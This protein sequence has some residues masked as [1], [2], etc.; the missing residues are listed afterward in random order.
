M[1]THTTVN[2]DDNNACTIDACDPI[3]G[4]SHTPVNA[5]D[6]LFCTVDACDP[7]T[8]IS[9]TPINVNDGNACTIDACDEANDMITHTPVIIDD[10]NAC[11]ID[12][13]DPI[14]GISH[15]PVNTDDGLFCTVDACDPITG[16]SHTPINVNDGNACTIDAC[17]EANDVITHT[18]VNVDDNNACTTDACDPITGITHTPVNADDGLFCTVDACDPITGISH[19]AINVNDGNACTIDACDEANDVITH[20]PVIIDDNNACTIDACDPITGI[21][22]TPSGPSATLLTTNSEICLGGTATISGTVT[23]TGAWTLTLSNGSTATGT[24]NG[25]FSIHVSPTATTIYTISSLIDAVCTAPSANLTGS[26]EIAI[27][28]KHPD[29]DALMDLYNATNGAGWTNNDG[30]EDGAAGTDCQNVCSWEGV[31]C[32]NGRVGEL[33][34]NSHNLSGTLPA[35]IGNLTNLVILD[36]SQNN[37]SNSLPDLGNLTNLFQLFLYDN[38]FSGQLPN[39]L[40]SSYY[41]FLQNNNFSGCFPSSYTAYCGGD[42]PPNFSG[43]PGLPGNGNFL[44]F[45]QK[46]TGTCCSAQI[47]ST[48]QI[49]CAGNDATITGDVTA[50]GAWTLTLSNGATATGN[51]DGSFSIVVHPSATTTYSIASLVASCSPQSQLLTG[52]TEITIGTKHPDFDALMDFYNA[53]NGANWTDKTGWE[54]GAA[55]INDCQSVCSWY[56][57]GCDQDNRISFLNME[58][59]NSGPKKLHFIHRF[60]S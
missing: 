58:G 25:L 38:N 37:L 24:G 18:P 60:L 28:I 53:T 21:T 27:A 41:I 20:T 46:G 29:F 19:T 4:I 33:Q 15:T 31:I 39:S 11:T 45:C 32:Y 43:N 9:H 22:H 30:W 2:V 55:G 44:K 5:D 59:N 35:S 57:V 14:T 36:L 3:T 1:I 56:G 26:T 16:V 40:G 12:A 17:D 42:A 54:D 49:I 50:N 6:G 13:C 10:N 23:A 47:T 7:I 48:A 8:G 52:S 51:G 34:L